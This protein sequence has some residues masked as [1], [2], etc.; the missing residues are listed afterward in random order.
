MGLMYPAEWKFK[1]MGVE[2]PAPAINDFFD[3]IAK[4]AKG[5]RNEKAIVETFKGAFGDEGNST[6]LGW[7]KTDLRRAMGK[8]GANAALF[9]DSFFSGMDLVGSLVSALPDEDDINNV[10]EKHS[11]PLQV[12]GRHLVLAAE[13]DAALV[14]SES[15]D[16]PSV[17]SKPI[18]VIGE[19]VGKGGF[20]IVYKATRKTST[21][22]FEF[23]MK[24][25]DPSPFQENPERALTRFQRETVTL[26]KLQHRGI[27]P[28]IDTGIS[29][30]GK[31]YILMQL[32][33]GRKLHEALAGAS[34]DRVR[35]AFKEILTALAYAHSLGV[36]HRDLKP[37]N[38]LVRDSDG[39]PIIVDFGCAY[40]L[41][42]EDET[43]ITTRFFGTT[44]YIPNEVM[45]NPKL[46]SKLH[47]I[48]SC[49]VMLYEV[50]AGYL[51]DPDN[52]QPL[53]EIRP[54]FASFDLVIQKS[55]APAKE[56]IPTANAFNRLLH[57]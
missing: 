19:R 53:A 44:A 26:N 40:L 55:L 45:R 50:V 21:S 16:V 14:S 28:Y 10:L 41:D 35:H 31:P 8:Q 12:N 25:L 49:G 34:P 17:D 32:I 33:E 48:Y 5:N 43:T 1:G 47:D 9:I 24:I 11:V 36:I 23:A 2:M 57:S 54:E 22:E 37:S 29:H 20:G 42:A 6:D 18:Y 51:P 38:V 7:A 27:V 4:I 13:G 15:E 52:Y 46:R 30:D 56:R 3:L 39:Q